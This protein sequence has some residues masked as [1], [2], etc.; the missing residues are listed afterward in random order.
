LVGQP[1]CQAMHIKSLASA[2]GQLPALMGQ[3]RNR[4]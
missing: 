2:M 4:N 3:T 1:E